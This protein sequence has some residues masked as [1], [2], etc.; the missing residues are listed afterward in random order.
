MNLQS[1]SKTPLRVTTRVNLKS[2]S[3]ITELDKDVSRRI[4][5]S[6]GE[7]ATVL[8]DKMKRGN[9]KYSLKWFGVKGWCIETDN[10]H[11]AYYKMRDLLITNKLIIE[12][13]PT[14]GYGHISGLYQLRELAY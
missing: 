9:F 14:S 10:G 3:M 8:H 6:L 13:I 11:R 7:P 1:V 2:I 12:V 4:L 5:K